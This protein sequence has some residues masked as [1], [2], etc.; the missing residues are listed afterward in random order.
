MNAPFLI[1]ERTEEGPIYFSEFRGEKTVLLTPQRD[2]ATPFEQL[3]A[4]SSVVDRLRAKGPAWRDFVVVD[5]SLKG[6]RVYPPL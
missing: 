6:M 2:A 5:T 3:D 1:V 4:A